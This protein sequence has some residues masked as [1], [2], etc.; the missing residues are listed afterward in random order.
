MI[1]APTWQRFVILIPAFLIGGGLILGM[2]V[3]L[4]RALVY[5]VRESGHARL[6][7]VALGLMVVLVVVLT[8]FGIQLPRE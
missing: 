7:V 3:L 6:I 2:L 8:Y 4:G 1:G 5:S